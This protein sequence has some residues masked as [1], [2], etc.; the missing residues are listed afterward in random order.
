MIFWEASGRLYAE[1]CYDIFKAE[2]LWE[3]LLNVFEMSENTSMPSWPSSFFLKLPV[4]PNNHI[5]SVDLLGSGKGSSIILK[6]R[7]EYFTLFRGAWTK[8]C[9]SRK[10][11]KGW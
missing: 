3:T 6:P 1:K 11:I 2:T 4:C 7:L 10:E 9:H 5:W 8:I